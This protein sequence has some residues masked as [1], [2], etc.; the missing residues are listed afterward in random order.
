MRLMRTSVT[1]D[2]ESES[3]LSSPRQKE[4]KINDFAG[5]FMSLQSWRMTVKFLV[6]GCRHSFEFCVAGAVSW[7]EASI[8]GKIHGN[9][10]PTRM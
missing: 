2:S 6:F 9:I 4:G 1:T 3:V 8:E 7:L 5:H 10:I